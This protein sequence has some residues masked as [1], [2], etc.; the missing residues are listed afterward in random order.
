MTIVLDLHGQHEP[1]DGAIRRA[2][3]RAVA[4]VAN[5]DEAEGPRWT[6]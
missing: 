3:E 5:R 1:D 4:V 6:T 2:I